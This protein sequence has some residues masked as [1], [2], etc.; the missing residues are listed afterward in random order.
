LNPQPS[1]Q[2]PITETQNG[3][4]FPGFDTDRFGTGAP[5]VFLHG[6]LGLKEHF[7]PS[8][9]QIKHRAECWLVQAPVLSLRGS[10]CSILG[11]TE[12]VQAY[13]DEHFSTPVVLVGNS[14]GGHLALRIA[15]D[16]P[17]RVR[18]IVLAGSSGLFERTFEKDVQH[19]PSRDWLDR[20]ISDLFYDPS[21]LPDGVVD[22][23]FDELSNRKAARALVRLSRTAKADHMGTRLPLIKQP[24]MLLWGRQDTVTPASVAEEFASLLPNAT[25]RWIEQCGHTP[26]I[27]RPD[28]F[29]AGLNEFLDRLGFPQ[30]DAEAQGVA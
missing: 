18:G 19:R 21:Q 15:L 11:V 12:L 2:T 4:S 30:A 26:M 8:A 20:K 3:A 7:A 17:E 13:L 9:E 1:P 27:E 10:Q 24:T 5:V 22:R 25:I 28:E 23:A 6:L 16:Q 29:A 14:L